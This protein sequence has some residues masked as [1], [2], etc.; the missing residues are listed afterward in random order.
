MRGC[1]QK[2]FTDGVDDQKHLETTD[3]DYHL[4]YDQGLYFLPLKN[5]KKGSQTIIRPV[6]IWW[7]EKQTREAP[8]H[9][10]F[11]LLSCQTCKDIL[12]Q[13]FTFKKQNPKTNSGIGHYCVSNLQNEL[14][15]IL[16][17]LKKPLKINPIFPWCLSQHS[18]PSKEASIT[19]FEWLIS[20][21]ALHFIL[22]V[23]FSALGFKIRVR[24]VK[25]KINKRKKGRIISFIP[26]NMLIK[27]TND[28]GGDHPAESH[29]SRS[30][31]CC[32]LVC[33]SNEPFSCQ[34]M[35]LESN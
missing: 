29:S 8:K 16:K 14:Y 17:L 4:S 1:T 7:K 35:R 27:G 2:V 5:N 21:L 6:S 9:I 24:Y 3:L 26:T 22:L 20:W 25:E 34:T 31:L 30:S 12:R 19:L 18:K 11:H 33:Q 13:V 28:R 23:W 15:V 32:N 10:S